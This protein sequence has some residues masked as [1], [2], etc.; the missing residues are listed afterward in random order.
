MTRLK[1]T[2]ETHYSCLFSIQ[3]T[4]QFNSFFVVNSIKFNLSSPL[5]Y[6]LFSFYLILMSSLI[7]QIPPHWNTEMCSVIAA[8]VPAGRQII[9]RSVQ[10]RRSLRPGREICSEPSYWKECSVPLT[11][12]TASSPG[13]P[14][15]LATTWTHGLADWLVECFVSWLLI[16]WLIDWPVS[17]VERK[18]KINKNDIRIL[19]FYSH[20]ICMKYRSLTV[21][22]NWF[23][24]FWQ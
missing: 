19:I 14:A 8:D 3:L 4:C 12:F 21:F 20:D 16:S 15:R 13:R 7:C 6:C 23:D 10:P 9:L 18:S 1:I 22:R 17:S 11:S 5:S 2:F 24:V